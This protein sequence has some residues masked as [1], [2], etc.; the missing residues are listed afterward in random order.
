MMSKFMRLMCKK[1]KNIKGEFGVSVIINTAI[2]LIITAF[3]LVPN[4]K[5]LATSMTTDMNA[6]YKDTVK[7]VLFQGSVTSSDTVEGSN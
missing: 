6:W 1:I 4:L 3:I 5:T 7:T 2:A